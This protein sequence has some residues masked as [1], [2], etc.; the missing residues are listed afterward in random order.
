MQGVHCVQTWKFPILPY[1]A[2]LRKQNLWIVVEKKHGCPDT[3]KLS[4]YAPFRLQSLAMATPRCVKF[5]HP[6]PIRS[7]L[8]IAP[9]RDWVK[10][11]NRPR[12]RVQSLRACK[13]ERYQQ[14]GVKFPK[15]DLSEAYR[16]NHFD[17]QAG[18]RSNCKLVLVWQDAS[19]DSYSR[20]AD[21]ALVVVWNRYRT[22]RSVP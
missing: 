20:I 4:S 6:E 10:N 7:L 5:D 17:Y 18:N 2:L 21:L 14:K 11:S 3:D 1:P 13:Q 15:L 16:C 9:K 19:R 12:R 22:V 8:K